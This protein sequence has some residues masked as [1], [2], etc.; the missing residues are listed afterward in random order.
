MRGGITLT[1]LEKWKGGEEALMKDID[2]YMN[3]YNN[4]VEYKKARHGVVHNWHHTIEEGNIVYDI[5]TGSGGSHF[6]KA[7]LQYLSRMN[8]FSKVE[9]G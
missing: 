1:P 9:V 4:A 5:D 3:E 8:A 2:T 6:L 7:L